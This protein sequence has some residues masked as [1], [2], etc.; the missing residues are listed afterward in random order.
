MVRLMVI[1]AW[2]YCSFLKFSLLSNCV[3]QL[4]WWI[5]WC[6]RNLYLIANENA[7]FCKEPEHLFCHLWTRDPLLK[8]MKDI[9]IFSFKYSFL[10]FHFHKAFFLRPRMHLLKQLVSFEDFCITHKVPQLYLNNS[11]YN[12]LPHAWE[13]VFH[14]LPAWLRGELV[15]CRG[16]NKIVFRKPACFLWWLSL[17]WHASF[18]WEMHLSFIYLHNIYK[19]VSLL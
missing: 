1:A 19:G 16:R 17:K 15:E 3:F 10:L 8:T 12:N 6:S 14:A 11:F 7:D 13:C 9:F 4:L 5:C 2:H 18:S